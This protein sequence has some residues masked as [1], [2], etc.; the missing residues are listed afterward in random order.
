MH[1]KTVVRIRRIF[2]AKG[3]T[4]SA[5][6]SCTGGLICHLLTTV[7]GASSYFR[8]GVVTY[9]AQSKRTLLGIEQK[10]FT[11]YGVVS[12]E[13]ARRM[14]E[15]IR[16]LTKTDIAVS[17]TGNLGPDV[18]EKKPKGLVYIAVSTRNGT[19]V[20]KCAF[21]GT[22]GQIKERA[23]HA[24]LELLAEVADYD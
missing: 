3:L 17:T 18:L 19:V 20:R 4:L 7:P 12:S 22:R 24:A 14:A 16:H 13:A 23:A 15:K 1:L 21:K 5:A 11:A 2:T 10:G 6:E 9:S 8:A